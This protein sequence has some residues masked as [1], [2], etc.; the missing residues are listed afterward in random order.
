MSGDTLAL[1]LVL[2]P[3]LIAAASLAGRRWGQAV[4]GWLVG[5]PLTSGP[6]AFFLALDHGADFAAA[7]AFGSLAGAI[8]EAAFCLAYG[9]T[10]GRGWP[11][12]L[13]AACGAFAI[14]AGALQRLSLGMLALAAVVVVALTA[15]LRA[16]PRPVATAAPSAP[17][18]WDIPARMLV[19]TALVVGLTELAPV[20]GPRLS[21]VLATFPVYAAIL[22][23]FAHR[24]GAAPA[25]LVLRGLLLGL[26]SFAGFFLV[27]G[28]LIDRLGIA[29]GFAAATAAALAI[30][31]ASL[32]LVLA[33]GSVERPALGGCGPTSS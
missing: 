5:L 9:W 24:A 6:V 13:T 16:T 14:A 10:A 12:A 11:L 21:G 26:F 7:A 31:A 2:T 30:Q 15:T 20:L 1:K 25:V 19:T 3:V 28:G 22:T 32:N 8:A 33:P 29:G 17:P 27:L 18:R 4:G 23:V